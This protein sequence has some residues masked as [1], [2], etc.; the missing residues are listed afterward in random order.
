MTTTTDRHRL[1][2]LDL[3]RFAA[4]VLVL[5]RHTG[6]PATGFLA[7]R[8]FRAGGWVGVD[9][10]FVLSGFLVSGLL[11]GEYQRRGQLDVGRF[12]IRRGFK[13]YPSFYVFLVFT[14]IWRAATNQ[15]LPLRGMLSE[16][17]FA[18]S[19]VRG[20]WDHTWSLAVEEHFYILLPFILLATLRMLGRPSD[21]FR[22]I[23]PITFLVATACLIARV[24]T[25]RYGGEYSYWKHQFPTHLRIDSLL[26]GV[27]IS[28]VYHFHSARLDSLKPFRFW[29]LSIGVVVML[30]T[31]VLK[32]EST[33]LLYTAGFTVVFVACGMILVGSLLC[34]VPHARP[35]QRLAWLGRFSYGIYLWHLT[36]KLWFIPALEHS[37]R[38]T[39]H[40]AMRIAVFWAGSFVVGI[41]MSKLVEF[42]ALRIRDRWFPSRSDAVTLPQNLK[43]LSKPPGNTGEDTLS[44]TV[45]SVTP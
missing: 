10:F 34:E 9:L 4:I 35:I 37:L 30:P 26:F 14:I 40:P 25:W 20:L 11:F 7:I 27:A 22:P 18:Q 24:L 45:E 39:F 15:S 28:Y 13:I 31:C 12:F 38:L 32:L 29:L 23:L 8:P 43:L 41:A 33:P 42:P 17:F 5:F 44:G 36:V 19:Y 3:L 1:I 6:L 2:A 21:P 16:T